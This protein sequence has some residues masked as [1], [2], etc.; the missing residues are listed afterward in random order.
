MSPLLRCVLCR[1]HTPPSPGQER[2]AAADYDVCCETCTVEVIRNRIAKRAEM[3][4]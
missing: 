3:N 4:E 1:D 2:Y